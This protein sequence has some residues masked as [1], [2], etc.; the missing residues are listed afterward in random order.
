MY[1]CKNAIDKKYGVFGTALN[2]LLLAL[3]FFLI[4]PAEGNAEIARYG[5]HVTFRAEC[6]DGSFLT[7]VQLS[8]LDVLPQRP[9]A[10]LPSTTEKAALPDL[11]PQAPEGATLDVAEDWSLPVSALTGN[12]ASFPS[13]AIQENINVSG[14]SF[15]PAKTGDKRFH[16][17]DDAACACSAGAVLPER[18]LHPTIEAL[19]TPRCLLPSARGLVVFSLP[20]PHTC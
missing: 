20:P 1:T 13:E 12:R 16:A 9:L 2:T 6:P 18:S 10:F 15:R 4:M 14:K 7:S 3:A 19:T 11:E 8:A 17:S 5:S